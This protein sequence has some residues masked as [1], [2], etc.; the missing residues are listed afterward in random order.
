[1]EHRAVDFD[2]FAIRAALGGLPLGGLRV[3][4]TIGS[5][6]DEALAWAAEG[7]ADLSVVIADEQTAGRGRLGRTWRTPRG[8]AI[9]VSVIL[10]GP[11]DPLPHYS[12]L[13]GLGAMAVADA[14]RSMGLQASIKWPNDILVEGRKLAGVLVESAWTGAALEAAVIGIGINVLEASGPPPESVRYPA[15]SMETSLGRP[16]IRAEVLR[17]L[18]SALITWRTKLDSDEFIAAWEKRLAWRG[19][20]VALLRDGQPPVRGKLS[21]LAPDGSLKILHEGRLLEVSMGELQLLATDDG[22]H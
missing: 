7:G 22:S 19:R 2:E 8:T 11:S 5:T 18:L 1:M 16:P 14:C 13:A 4:S 9:A 10:R 3:L 17:E 15:T 20:Q 6:N 12:R 21:G